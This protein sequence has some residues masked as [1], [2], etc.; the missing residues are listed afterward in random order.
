[1]SKHEQAK[2][3]DTW[4]G[5]WKAVAIIGVLAVGADVLLDN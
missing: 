4:D 3:K 2:S 1:M 5:F